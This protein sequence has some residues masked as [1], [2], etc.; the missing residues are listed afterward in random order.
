MTERLVG[1]E[2]IDVPV[3]ELGDDPAAGVPV[4]NPAKAALHVAEAS[5]G[6]GLGY[7]KAAY[8]VPTKLASGA[9]LASLSVE[10][11]GR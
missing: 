1:I 9:D 7:S 6:C 8:P 11:S 5:V 3:L 10:G 2:V 4:V